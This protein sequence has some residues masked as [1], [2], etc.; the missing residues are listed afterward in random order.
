M[1]FMESAKLN[2]HVGNI[3]NYVHWQFSRNNEADQSRYGTKRG[4]NMNGKT[5]MKLFAV[6]AIHVYEQSHLSG[7]S[8]GSF[9]NLFLRLSAFGQTVHPK[10]FQI[11]K[12]VIFLIYSR[13]FILL[14]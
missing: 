10:R 11:L 9:R 13:W 6:S 7:Y 2:E 8:V 5:V 12:S 4:K 14:R 1:Q 3:L